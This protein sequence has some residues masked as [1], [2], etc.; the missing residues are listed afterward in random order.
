MVMANPQHVEWLQEGAEAWNARR[1]TSFIPDLREMAFPVSRYVIKNGKRVLKNGQ[2]LTD[3]S[4]DLTGYDFGDADLRGAIFEDSDFDP[5]KARFT[6]ADVRT[7][8][9]NDGTA[10]PTN[11]TDVAGLTQTKLNA[12]RGDRGTILPEGLEYPPDWPE[13]TRRE[14]S[15]E[16]VKARLSTN[17]PAVILTAAS[18]LEQVSAFRETVRGNNQFASEMPESHASRLDFLETLSNELHHLLAILPSDETPVTE[19]AAKETASWLDQF[20]DRLRG[21]AEKYIDPDNVA[22]AASPLGIILG[23]GAIGALLGGPI[24]F[25][26]GSFMGNYLTI[27]LKP[28]AVADKIEKIL[29]QNGEGRQ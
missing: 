5:R 23:C 14:L 24:G 7:P 19:E 17:R 16:V 26:A 12:M 10:R 28:G 20:G 9:K 27:N 29:E 3:G 2:R 25:G 6:G 1:R 8:F 21:H 18:V 15:R 11:L 4:H 13:A 22:D